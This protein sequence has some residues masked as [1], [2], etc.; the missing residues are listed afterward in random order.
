MC[1]W[2]MVFIPI[3]RK[4]SPS[5]CPGSKTAPPSPAPAACEQCTF[6]KNALVIPGPEGSQLPVLPAF[7]C[8]H[9]PRGQGLKAWRLPGSTL[10]S[11][12]FTWSYAGLSLSLGLQVFS[13][14][15]LSRSEKVVNG[16][17]VTELAHF[18]FLQEVFRT[19]IRLSP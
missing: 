16:G 19:G 7:V 10:A 12:G 4:G 13:D 15:E 2:D 5:P 11:E 3:L 14:P 6:T 1:N 9:C 18:T 17:E 8:Q